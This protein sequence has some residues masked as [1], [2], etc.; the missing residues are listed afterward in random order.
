MKRN[1]LKVSQVAER[2]GVSSNTVLR[3]IKQGSLR[4]IE[5]PSSGKRSTYRIDESALATVVR[6]SQRKAPEGV[7]EII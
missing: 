2:F 1:L 4:A 3:W 6:S 5:L 7:E